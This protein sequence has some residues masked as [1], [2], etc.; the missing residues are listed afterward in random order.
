MR[1]FNRVSLILATIAGLAVTLSCGSSLAAVRA[2][3]WP[4][5]DFNAQ[6]TGVGPTATGI[7]RADL[8]SL[9]RITVHIPGTVD[10]APVELHA[11]QVRG[12]IHDVIIVTT[13]YGRTLALDAAN[14]RRLWE[15]A[16]PSIRS[17]FGSAQITTA[18]PEVDPDRAHVYVTTPDGYVHKLSVANGHQLWET[19]LTYDPRREKLAGALNISGGA[20]LVVT[21]GY[22]GDPPSYQGHIAAL[23]LQTGHITHLWNS[24]CSNIKTL[25]DP[26]SRCPS[27]DS[28]IWGRSGTVVEPDTGNILIATGN[29]PFNGHTDWGD[30]VLELS[31]TLE[32]LHN[33]TP[34]DQPQLNNDDVDLGSTEPALL[35]FGAGSR[36][37]VQGG[38]SGILSLL[39]LNRLDGGRRAAG[40]KTGGSLQAIDA[41][42]TAGVY[43]QPAVWRSPGGRVYVYVTTGAGTAAYVLGANRRLRLGWRNDQAGT[44]PLIAGGLLYVYNQDHG[45]LNVMNPRSG[46]IYRALRAAPGHWNS[47][48]VIGGRIIL[49]VGDDNDHRNTGE[50]FIYHLPD[51]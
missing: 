32:L 5:F 43:S 3:D 4:T 40:P 1:R 12:S 6:R 9:R 50:L 16:P 29:A 13:S 17:L 2:G 44:S 25:I 45:V 19:R 30:S 27:S 42:G 34:V 23:D 21:G 8:H 37:A 20:L 28:A 10:S 18:T 36:L 26:P 47:P 33:W 51:V 24:L 46:R 22:Y 7:T 14:G 11:V 41:P 31:P 48:I 49:P 38:K 35:P 39:N 15:F